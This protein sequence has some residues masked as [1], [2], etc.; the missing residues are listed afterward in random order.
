MS[1]AWQYYIATLIVYFGV[2]VI[3]CW[4]L[5]LQYGVAGIANFA[6]IVFQAVGA[7]TAAITSLG[8]ASANG[9]YQ[10]YFA[11]W[12]LPWPLPLLAAGLAGAV[13][14]GAV[15]TFAL[16]PARRDYQA[17]VMLI[18]AI[19]VET[20]VSSEPGFLNGT[21]GLAGVPQPLQTSLNV[22]VAGYG[23]FFAGLTIAIA[24]VVYFVVHRLTS[25]PWALRLRGMRD[26][27]VAA[28]ALGTNVTA[29][30]TI[31][32]V[33]GGALAALSGGIL[34]EFISA[35]S[36]G[37]WGYIETFL[38]FTAIIVGGAGNNFGVTLGA[39]LVL[40]VISE[41]LPFLPSF[42]YAGTA[43]SAQWIING[44]LILAFLWLRPQG[45]VPERKR[46]YARSPQQGE[47]SHENGAIWRGLSVRSD[48]AKSPRM[49]DIVDLSCS[50]GGVRA[51]DNV[52]LSVAPGELLGIIGPNGA[53][54]STLL[55]IVTG[56]ERATGGRVVF[57]GQDITGHNP[58]RLAQ[59]GLL[60]TFQIPAEFARL[61]VLENLMSVAPG[62]RGGSAGG[63]LLG[64]RYWRGQQSDTVER[65]RQLL[66]RF[67]LAHI[68]DQYAGELSGGQKRL[69]EMM[70]AL[71]VQPSLLLLDE[72]MAGVDPTLRVRLENHLADLHEAGLTMVMVEH[73]MGIVERL[74]SRIV[75]LAEGRVLAEGAM[76]ELRS[77]EAVLE[78]YL[79]G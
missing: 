63:A 37:S 39:L 4:A 56:T 33:V 66:S 20:V 55:K 31:V 64:K 71:M 72:P 67:G 25:S 2:N 43:E 7:Y 68:E 62:Q 26:D 44:F 45:I 47:R 34:V 53:G 65:A 17:M 10:T 8:P 1:A 13:V 46:R 60:R 5:N 24:I 40:T 58:H 38:Y 48:G 50:F 73:E 23:W 74:C 35:W 19:V 76:R 30:T 77:D 9:G 52:S 49:L 61:T 75:V 57:N 42:G 3:A 51:L 32:Y 15:C 21:F 22:G 36:P 18:V 54:K 11:G 14:S 41:S 6:F 78:A 29:Q 69:L 16:R 27:P 28:D 79:A 12:N 59:R 70:R